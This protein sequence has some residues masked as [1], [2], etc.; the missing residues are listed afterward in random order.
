MARKTFLALSAAV[1]I[2]LTAC[3]GDVAEN[4]TAASGSAAPAQLTKVTAGIIPISNLTPFHVAQEKGFFKKNGLEVASTTATAGQTL[5]SALTGGSVQFAYS[6][7]LSAV[8]AKAGGIDLRIVAGQNSAQLSGTDGMA[9]V[10]K[11]DSPIKTVADLKGQKIA[12]NSLGS[13]NEVATNTTLL[14]AGLK[15]QDVKYVEIPFSS[16]ADT[17]LRGDV[18][19]AN[20]VEPFRT[21]TGDKLRVINHPFVDM[22]PGMSIAG[23]MATGQ[24]VD[25]NKDVV[26]KFVAALAEANDY[27]NGDAEEKITWTAKFTKSE[28][29][30][31]RRL[32]LDRWTSEVDVAGLQ[33][34]A[35]LSVEY[36]I[37]SKQVEVKSMIH[38]TAVK[39]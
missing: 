33:K 8:N 18:A 23:W 22:H 2:S 9:L 36:Q 4:K 34:I 19:A 29:E 7:L 5:L 6:D 25:K 24:Y 26:S 12:L 32:T 37:L 28:P 38:E 21:R 3:G 14:K 11:S 13:L 10:V 30:L 20:L 1:L 39:R 16:I 27:L 31:I 35:D 17:L 15:P